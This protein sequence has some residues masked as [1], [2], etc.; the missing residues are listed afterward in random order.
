MPPMPVPS[1]VHG[2]EIV[3][4][5]VVDTS[6]RV[7]QDSVTICGLQDPLYLQRVAE[8]VSAMR[9]RPGLMRAKHV[10]A[11]AIFPFNF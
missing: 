4:R 7:V 9:F 1:T 10:I 11:P 2:R 8:E 6:G 3:V 5:V